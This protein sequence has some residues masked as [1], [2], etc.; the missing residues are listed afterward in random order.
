MSGAGPSNLADLAGGDPAALLPTLAQALEPLVDPAALTVERQRSLGDRMAGRP[1]RVS[2]LSIEGPELTL[3]LKAG[4]GDGRRIS[5]EAA[6]VV[7]GVI[8]SRRT[9]PL[10]EWLD[11]LAGQL[12][13]LARASAVDDAAVSRTLAALGVQDATSD[14]MVTAA[15]VIGGL[16][17]LPTRLAGR[18]PADVIGTVE[19]ICARLL[20][21]LPRISGVSE[22]SHLVTATATDYLPRTLRSYV[23]LPSEWAQTHRLSDGRTALDVLREQ[24]SV[25]ELSVDRMFEAVAAADADALL[26]NG[27]F[28]RDRFAGSDSQLNLPTD[29]A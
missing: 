19:R 20:E 15:D 18:V 4:D 12:R 23:S 11:L 28:L 14:L 13:E 22:Q 7:R 27:Y 25:L 2:A 21:T 8:I 29:P 6:R 17:L 26:A 24:L 5:A 16:R 10:A 3:S 1:G 9:V